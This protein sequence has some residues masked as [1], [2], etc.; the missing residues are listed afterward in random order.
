LRR[1]TPPKPSNAPPNNSIDDGSGTDVG[2]PTSLLTPGTFWNLTKTA[3]QICS[4]V[5]PENAAPETVNEALSPGSSPSF[6]EPP[7]KLPDGPVMKAKS[8][9]VVLKP[10]GTLPT[11]PSEKVKFEDRLGAC[12]P[13]KP[14]NPEALALPPGGKSNP[15]PVIVDVDPGDVIAEV[16]V[17]VKV[18]VL[19]C[20]LKSQTIEAVEDWPEP[21]PTIVIVSARAVRPALAITS[22][23]TTEK[24][25]LLYRDMKNA[26]PCT[27]LKHT[28][29]PPSPHTLGP[30]VHRKDCGHCN[31][32]VFGG[33]RGY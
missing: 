14:F 31:L 28:P 25:S 26:P 22:S 3:L 11:S 32:T 13:V 15:I 2:V 10:S 12:I 5:N 16:F 23:A 21:V 17:I 8:S 33:V 1:P 18:N 9:T 6:T 20:E 19:V 7:E 30:W 29:T 27:Y 24:I 4:A